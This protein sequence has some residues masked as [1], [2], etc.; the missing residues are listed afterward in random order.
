MPGPAVPQ[1]SGKEFYRPGALDA[2]YD[3]LQHQAPLPTTAPPSGTS[4]GAPP[5]QAFIPS[6]PIDPSAP[7]VLDLIRG[8][9]FKVPFT[10][11]L[12][13][14]E[15]VQTFK[16]DAGVKTEANFVLCKETIRDPSDLLRIMAGV[17]AG[18]YKSLN[19]MTLEFQLML[20][21][22]YTHG[23]L[24]VPSMPVPSTKGLYTAQMAAEAEETV[25]HH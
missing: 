22:A 20:Y 1:N 16:S 5:S 11:S 18:V 21:L 2:E 24:D 7:D 25:E 9:V 23:A 14:R 17:E 10:V 12:M 6:T 13:R 3:R 19:R 4:T 8:G 15:G